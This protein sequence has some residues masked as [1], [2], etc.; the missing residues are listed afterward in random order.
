MGPRDAASE[1]RQMVVFRLGTEAYGVDVFRVS[2]IIRLRDITPVPLTKAHIRG[3]VNLRG[4]TIPVVDLRVRLQLEAVEDTSSTR[5]V[6]V[7]TGDGLVGLLVDEARDVILMKAE[8]IQ[9][10]PS[11]G[12]SGQEFVLGV[13]VRSEGLITILDLDKALAA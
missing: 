7:E 12:D 4:Q 8:D 10:P 13:G 1:Q 6:V 11:C 9:A 5:I 3:L 2:E